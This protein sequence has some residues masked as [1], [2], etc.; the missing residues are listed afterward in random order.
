MAGELLHQYQLALCGYVTGNIGQHLFGVA[1]PDPSEA[2]PLRWPE[3]LRLDYPTWLGRQLPIGLD[4]CIWPEV[5]RGLPRLPLSDEEL[6]ALEGATEGP[7]PRF[8]RDWLPDPHLHRRCVNCVPEIQ[9][10][11]TPQTAEDWTVACSDFAKRLSQNRLLLPG[12]IAIVHEWLWHLRHLLRVLGAENY[13]PYP[14]GCSPT[15]TNRAPSVD[16]HDRLKRLIQN[17]DA[18]MLRA[19]NT[20][21]A[22]V[23]KAGADAA[24]KTLL[25]DCR[26]RK[27]TALDALRGLEFNGEYQ[28]FDRQRAQRYREGRNNDR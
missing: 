9:S 13:L 3:L 8:D 21:R 11:L 2:R 22:L 14:Q 15:P 18:K 7:A 6:F 20:M 23:A 16:S 19:M 12:G 5:K 10:A 4:D 17:P 1:R 28:G 26:M 24:P 25:K 27:K